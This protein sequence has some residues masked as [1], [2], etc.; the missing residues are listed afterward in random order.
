MAQFPAVDLLIDI[1]R[2]K[3]DEASAELAG[4]LSRCQAAEQKLELLRRYRSEYLDRR[5]TADMTCAG[6]LCNFSAFMAKLD[7]AISSQEGALTEARQSAARQR[8][9]WESTQRQVK[10]MEILRD[11]RNSAE[12]ILANRYQ[13][14]LHDELAGRMTTRPMALAG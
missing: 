2:R 9:H 12:R 6:L 5:K 4:A 8:Q 1:A 11:R 13:Q 7:N 14:K 3:C 10:A